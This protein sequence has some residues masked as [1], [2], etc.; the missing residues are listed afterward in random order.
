[1][2]KE[3]VKK[4]KVTRRSKAKYP[5]LQ[6]KYNL[7]MRRDY[8]EPDYINGVRDDDGNVV[9]RPLNDE[10]KNFLNN[11]Y[12]EVINAN[13]KHDYELRDL[14]DQIKELKAIENP[15][16]AELRKLDCLR[17][18]YYQ[19]ADE[20]LL[21]TDEEDQ[22]KI[23]NENNSRNRCL[24]TRIKSSG[25]LVEL[26]NETYQELHEAMYSCHRRGEEEV[27][28]KVCTTIIKNKPKTLSEE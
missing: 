9:I 18:Q 26:N 4:R 17:L 8:I 19:R 27:I 1:M 13:F 6:K 16:K 23:Y 20:V 11:F 5:A 28:A 7:K 22:R 25:R 2:V 24:Y 3:K 14:N 12:E 15:T 21:F 10:E